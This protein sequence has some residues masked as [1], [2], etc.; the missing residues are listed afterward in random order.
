MSKPHVKQKG[1]QRRSA[2]ALQV[3]NPVLAAKKLKL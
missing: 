3:S 1:Y 2:E